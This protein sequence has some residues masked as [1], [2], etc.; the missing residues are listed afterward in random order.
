M[1]FYGFRNGVQVESQSYN[2]TD[3]VGK[4]TFNWDSVDE[5]RLA[6]NTYFIFF[7]RLTVGA[8]NTL[9]VGNYVEDIKDITLSPNPSSELI[10]I[11]GISKRENYIIYNF[12]GKTIKNGTV[13]NNETIDINNFNNGLY[14]IKF[15]KGNALKFLKK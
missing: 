11:S 2:L 13:S 1:T 3:S 12:L 4:F 6:A 5:V 14:F 9:S 15:D 7:D 8:A 10:K